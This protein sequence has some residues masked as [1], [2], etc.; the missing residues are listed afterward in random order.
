MRVRSVLPVCCVLLLFVFCQPT[1]SQTASPYDSVDP[2]IGTDGGGNTFPGASL[3]FGMV[4]W[5]PD[6]NTDAWY[7]HSENQLYGFSLTHI[8]GAGCPLYGDFAVLGAPMFNK[9]TLRFA[10]D[11]TLV[12]SKSGDGIYVDSALLDGLPFA[13]SWLPLEK[14][15]AGTTHLEFKMST[16]PNKERGSAAK[17]RPPLFR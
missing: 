4:Q 8:S 10:E 16:Q 1:F 13:G 2:I 3:P 14:I 6:T 5:S 9:A 12:I 17:D 11:S 7:H 15:R